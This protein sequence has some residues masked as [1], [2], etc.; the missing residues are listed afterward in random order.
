VDVRGDAARATVPARAI[1]A[2]D[3]RIA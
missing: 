1:A 2:L 3:L